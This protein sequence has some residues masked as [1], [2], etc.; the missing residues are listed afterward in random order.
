MRGIQK[1]REFFLLRSLSFSKTFKMEL[2][3]ISYDAKWMELYQNCV[4]QWTFGFF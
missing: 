2:T 3:D 1:V 4:Q